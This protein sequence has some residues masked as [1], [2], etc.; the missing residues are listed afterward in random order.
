[1]VVNIHVS[2]FAFVQNIYLGYFLLE[3]HEVQIG[4]V[5]HVK[6]AHH[7]QHP[8]LHLPRQ[9]ADI[10]QLS[11]LGFLN[12]EKINKAQTKTCFITKI[13]LSKPMKVIKLRCT[14]R[15]SEEKQKERCNAIFSTR[16]HTP[17]K[18]PHLCNNKLTRISNPAA[19]Q[20]FH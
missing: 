7:S 19:Q 15:I 1:M 17:C 13:K 11:Q 20:N 6:A 2:I 10:Q 12:K 4:D 9:G 8:V 16:L 14:V 18:P 3:G 5:D